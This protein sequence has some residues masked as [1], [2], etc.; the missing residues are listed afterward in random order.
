M[1]VSALLHLDPNSPEAQVFYY[2]D[3]VI[4]NI[5][6]ASAPSSIPEPTTMSPSTGSD[7]VPNNS[8]RTQSFRKRWLGLE[9]VVYIFV[10]LSL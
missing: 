3:K 10:I 9:V 1:D 4:N 7:V 6:P 5:G 2:V 8:G